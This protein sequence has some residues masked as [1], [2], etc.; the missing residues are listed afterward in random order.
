MSTGP[1]KCGSAVKGS[2]SRVRSGFL[3]LQI[4]RAPALGCSAGTQYLLHVV[5]EM[6]IHRQ[7]FTL[8]N[9]APAEIQ[10][11]PFDNPGNHVRIARVI[12]VLRPT[13]PYQAVQ[14]PIVAKG[15]DI[16]QG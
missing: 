7:L 9:P 10:N 13:S 15:K 12:Y 8:A 5:R 2:L 11:V 4:D 16:V 14:R 6:I 3:L 1:R